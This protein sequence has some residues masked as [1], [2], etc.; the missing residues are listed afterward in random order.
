MFINIDS[1]RR[2]CCPRL[3]R[4]VYL[5]WWQQDGVTLLIRYVE[6]DK[7]LEYHSG[8]RDCHENRSGGW[9]SQPS[10]HQTTI[11]HQHSFIVG[12]IHVHRKWP[13]RTTACKPV[14]RARSQNTLGLL[15]RRAEPSGGRDWRGRF[16]LEQG[17]REVLL[18]YTQRYDLRQE[19][20]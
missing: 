8:R 12:R 17:I 19:C 14:H 2:M 3:S 16:P 9:T 11:P 5:V 20:F 7:P 4:F 15:A 10:R 18:L 1:F 6:I 13:N